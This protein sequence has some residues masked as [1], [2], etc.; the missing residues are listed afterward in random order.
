MSTKWLPR[1]IRKLFGICYKG[2]FHDWYVMKD[3]SYRTCGKCNGQ[4]YWAYA[5]MPLERVGWTDMPG[6]RPK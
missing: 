4:Q 5:D 1:W 3:G 6:S 2:G